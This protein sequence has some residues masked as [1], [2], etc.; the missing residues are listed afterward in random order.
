MKRTVK[1]L[2]ALAALAVSGSAMAHKS[3]DSY[4]NLETRGA[5]ITGRWDIALR[6]LD[7]A[8]SLDSNDD[9]AITWGELKA[10]EQAIAAYALPRL[11][12]NAGGG[13]C[14]PK[15]TD[16]LVGTHTDGA[17]ASLGLE[18]ACAGAATQLEIAYS[19]FADLD[20]QHRGL[21]N[22]KAETGVQT[23][24]F[25]PEN[26]TRTLEVAKPAPLAQFLEFVRQGV[27]HIWDGIDHILFL[28]ALLL[29]SVLRREAG[30]WVPVGDLRGA[31]TSVLKVVTAFTLAHSITLSLASLGVISLPSRLVESVIAASV[32]LA[33]LNN[34]FPVVQ[35]R[36]RWLVA[37]G[38]GLIHGF[39]FASVLGELGLPKDALVRSLVGFNVGVELGQLAIVV[40]FVPL[41]F[42]LRS[43]LFYR[44]FTLAVGSLAVAA[45]A[46]LW[47]A[48]R[49]F[50]LKFLPI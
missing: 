36:R 50:D 29:P 24:I 21:L 38:F 33:A 6:D 43:T 49:I 39:G 14:A 5:T 26:P 23:A 18:Y 42:A 34:V 8:I 17:Y 45:I 37:F 47:M 12:L 9:G 1:T 20:P 44:R 15:T 13:A 27:L 3:S 32:V 46:A 19:L 41:A 4:L 11:T 35:E 7:F 2:V 25:S 10:Q 28:L 22:L 40:G 48:E 30:R 31:L 16:F